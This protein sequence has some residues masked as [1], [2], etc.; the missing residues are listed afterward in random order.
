VIGDMGVTCLLK[1]GV[2][3]KVDHKYYKLYEGKLRKRCF[4]SFFVFT[5][6]I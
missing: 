2:G 4:L 1:L 6:P 5:P 3:G